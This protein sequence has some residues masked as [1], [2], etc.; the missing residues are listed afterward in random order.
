MSRTSLDK[1][2]HDPLSDVLSLLQV[3]NIRCTRLEA[4]GVW[5]LSFAAQPLLKFVAVLRGSCWLQAGEE[6]H[7][8]AA[9]D[10]F[11]LI[12]AEGYAIGNASDAPLQDG[13]RLFADADTGSVR[14]Q[15]ADTILL[16]GSFVVASDDLTF[17]LE[18]LPSLIRVAGEDEAAGMVQHN[19]RILDAEMTAPGLGHASIVKRL[20]DLL[21]LQALRAYASTAGTQAPGWIGALADRHVGA[22]L[23]LMH[24]DVGRRWTVAELAAATGLSRSAF[25]ARFRSRVGLPP[26]DYHLRWRMHRARHALR[27]GVAIATLAEELGYGSE[28]AFGFAFRRVVGESPARFRSR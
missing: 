16:G 20:S 14:L 8:L 24:A 18:A 3:R 12:N 21:L 7:T 10:A 25:A 6:D 28:S 1:T 27:A 11:F 26:L 2:P 22:A 15:G 19:L 13:G 17:L 9:G 23:H 5:G 4:G